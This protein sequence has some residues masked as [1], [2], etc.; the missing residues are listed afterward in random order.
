MGRITPP[1]LTGRK[2]LIRVFRGPWYR[3]YELKYRSAIHFGKAARNRFD[4]PAGEYGVL[5][6]ARDIEGAFVETLMH[7]T[8]VALV[9]ES[10]LR[11]R[12]LVEVTFARPLRL[13]DL[14]AEG[15]A[16]LGVD[17]SLT[18]GPQRYYATSRRWSKALRDH[19]RAPDGIAYRSRH[20][21]A[22]TCVA[23]FD[24]V[25]PELRC[26]R[27]GR[28]LMDPVHEPKLAS[29]LA[30]YGVGLVT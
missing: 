29:I 3:I 5:Y 10:D 13:V 11:A 26:T 23:L 6:A 21:P 15:L 27:L 22:R 19:P 16:R 2:P 24:H 18:C 28:S 25:E 17:A 20:D 8:G 12:G 14:R 30:T 4:A 7:D 1:D 9:S